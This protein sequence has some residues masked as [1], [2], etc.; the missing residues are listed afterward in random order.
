MT[1]LQFQDETHFRIKGIIQEFLKLYTFVHFINN[2]KKINRD[3]YF[4]KQ[5]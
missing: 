4:L 1:S 5:T 3:L 2:Q